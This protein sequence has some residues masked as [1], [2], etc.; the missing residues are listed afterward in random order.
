M[1]NKYSRNLQTNAFLEKKYKANRNRINGSS[2][3]RHCAVSQDHVL[4][5]ECPSSE[6][7]FLQT[8][9]SLTEKSLPMNVLN[10]SSLLDFY[11]PGFSGI[12]L[13]GKSSV[14]QYL[15]LDT[16]LDVL[17][18]G[19]IISGTKF[20]RTTTSTQQAAIADALNN[21]GALWKTTINYANPSA[22]HGKP[23]SDERN[24]A[25]AI[26]NDYYQPY[27]SI[28]CLRDE[29]QGVDD[30]RSMV[31]P[32]SDFIDYDSEPGLSININSSI[33]NYPG[34]DFPSIIRAQ[35][36]LLPGS[37]S[38]NRIKWVQL[39]ENLFTGSAL[40]LIVLLPSDPLDPPRDNA[41]Q[42]LVCTIG[43][44]WGSTSIGVQSSSDGMGITSSDLNMNNYQP[45]SDDSTPEDN[46]INYYQANTDIA[47]DY[48]FPDYPSKTIEIDEEWLEYLDPFIPTLN[49]SVI[50][51]LL[52]ET[53][54]SVIPAE[55]A[56]QYIVGGLLANGLARVGYT[57]QLQ[58]NVKLAQG[59]SGITVPD[60]TSWV[61]GKGDIF[62]VDP[63]ES[64]DWVRLR[65]DSTMQGYA[66]NT[67]GPSPKIAIAFLLTYS[68]LALAHC[69]YSGISGNCI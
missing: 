20:P 58:G 56:T 3:P 22:H 66:Y 49:T 40:G 23:F 48:A 15:E 64:K 67:I 25:H 30:Q 45:F 27:V 21:A 35:L 36:L 52:K 59:A 50:N 2:V 26:K 63:N 10:Q 46:G 53:A 60:I 9:M 8:W 38:D 41:T 57:S 12:P 54:K 47:V 11:S 44:G 4:P 68:I 31:F 62:T 37:R 39:P 5:N 33:N 18:D 51:F 17:K 43:A 32:I 13:T 65:V 19:K 28:S 1:S 55:V 29:I 34:I 42:M 24:A 61:S 16:S 69:F 6:W 14:R 7:Q